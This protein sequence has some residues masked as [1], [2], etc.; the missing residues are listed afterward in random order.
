[1][2]KMK[3]LSALLLCFALFFQL[4]PLKAGA[5]NTQLDLLTELTAAEPEAAFQT[6]KLK[7]TAS[8]DSLTLEFSFALK[9]DYLQDTVQSF[10]DNHSEIDLSDDAAID[11]ACNDATEEELPQIGFSFSCVLDEDTI[12]IPDTLLGTF[13]LWTKGDPAAGEVPEKIGSYT[14]SKGSGANS[15]VLTVDCTLDKKV[16][17]RTDVSAS[18]ALELD[19]ESGGKTDPIPDLEAREGQVFVSVIFSGGGGGTDPDEEIYALTKAQVSRDDSDPNISYTITATTTAAADA[20]VNLNGLTIRD[21]IPAG[22]EVTGVDYNDT[23]LSETDY[24]IADGVLEYTLPEYDGSNELTLAVLTV[25]TRLTAEKYQEYLNSGLGVDWSFKNSASLYGDDPGDPLTVSNEVTSKFKSAFL[26]KDGELVGVNGNR[27]LWTI[28]ADTYFNGNG[29]VYLVDT[30]AGIDTT[31]MYETTTPGDNLSFTVGAEARTATKDTTGFHTPYSDLTTD[32]LNTLTGSDSGDNTN[33]ANAVYYTY[34]SDSNGTDDQAVLVIPLKESD[35]NAPLTVTYYTKLVPLPAGEE[36]YQS[37][38]LK[39]TATMLW[40]WVGYGV[41]PGPGT[42]PVFDFNLTKNVTAANALLQKDDGGYTPEN[43]SM[44]WEFTVNQTGK[45]L[46]DAVVTDVL[47]DRLQAFS[48]LT[49]QIKT[50]TDSAADVTISEG[51]EGDLGQYYSLTKD[52]SANKTTL[53]IHLGTVAA[54]EMYLLTLKTTV[55][56]PDFLSKES[57]ISITNSAQIDAKISGDPVHQE[58]SASKTISNTLLIKDALRLNGTVGTGYNYQTHAVN[59]RI[60][61]NPN[62]VTL[63]TPELKDELPEGATFGELTKVTRTDINGTTSS[64]VTINVTDGNGTVAFSDGLTITLAKTEGTSSGGYSK[65]TETFTFDHKIDDQFVFEFSTVIDEDYRDAKFKTNDS[66]TFT[67]DSTLTGSVPDPTDPTNL[68]KDKQVSVSDDAVQ[69]AAVPPVI[70]SG[71]YYH[72]N[73]TAYPDLGKLDYA[74][75]TIVVNKDAIDM[76]GVRLT[77]SLPD[78][79]ELDPASLSIR[80]ATVAPDGTATPTADPPITEGLTLGY[81]GFTFDIPNANARTPLVITFH[82][83]VVGTADASAMKNTVSLSW[84]GGGSTDSN[85]AGADGAVS[86]NAENFATAT[87]APLLQVLK[88]STNTEYD[89]SGDPLFKLGGAEF[90]LTPMKE[91]GGSW[92]VDA[93]GIPKVRSTS[94]A[95]LANFFF[96]K[97]DVL[98]RLTETG[99]PD[100]YLPDDTPRY[101][102]FPMAG[103]EGNFPTVIG[104]AAVNV[105]TTTSTKQVV[106]NEPKNTAPGGGSYTLSFTKKTDTG[107]PLSGAAFTLRDNSGKLKDKTAVSGADGVVTF[108]HI[109]AGSYTLTET[110]VPAGFQ[111][112]PASVAV[113]VTLSG[114][115]YSVS[116]SGASVSGGAAG[117]YALTN[118]YIRGTVGLIKTDSFSGARVS[119]AEFSVYEAGTDKLTAYL[120]EGGEPGR[121]VL[122]ETNAAGDPVPEYPVR[123]LRGDPLLSSQGGT[124]MLLAGDY[125]ITETTAPNGYLPDND[126]SGTP[127]RHAFSIT[128][129]GQNVVV[130]SQ[131]GAFTNVPCGVISGKKTTTGG[132]PLANAVIGLFPAGTTSFTQEN[133]YNGIKVLSETDGS[134]A[135]TRVPYGTYVIAELSAPSGYTLNRDTSFIV[136]VDQNTAAVTQDDSGNAIVIENKRKPGSSNNNNQGKYGDL[137]IQKTSEDGTLAGFTFVVSGPAGY[138]A[139][140]TTDSEGLIYISGLR[141][142]TYTV[143]EKDTAQTAG[144]YVLPAARTVRLTENGAKLNFYNKLSRSE[145]PAVPSTPPANPNAPDNTGGNGG[146]PGQPGED[147]GGNGIALGN[148]ENEPD[149]SGK[150]AGSGPNTGVPAYYRILPAVSALSLLGFCVCFFWK[151]RGRG[152]SEEK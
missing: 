40:D 35:L 88:T 89:G 61:A 1:M 100:G 131:P 81:S 119:G 108:P 137:S 101:Y 33:S 25:H 106:P 122:S 127:V 114:G 49:A 16:Y 104:S 75:W 2:R 10:L 30:I 18:G 144:R 91:V 117:G 77:D 116:M 99:A 56:D 51:A 68:L 44:T 141:E 86:F 60:T 31:H 105:V 13:E 74:D 73:L 42:S 110:A 102:V 83:L 3:K 12:S 126:A 23:A 6:L 128:S 72:D 82:T 140:F 135:F 69:T 76:T 93:D 55:V 96:L 109:D 80:P 14:V 53:K 27:Y 145:T 121:Y 125:Y 32:D 36:E 149:G 136:T 152:S 123:N 57:S 50:T 95:G 134:F 43:R 87:R 151:K 17:H 147:I 111:P 48:G 70:K 46:T 34:D 142:G 5:E 97:K 20:S 103:H 26:A 38:E 133:L 112:L 85:Q 129:A 24:T 59:W 150:A 113:D 39:N 29:H 22:L 132:S 84:S 139:E 47:D 63:N 41:G 8:E 64:P 45:E 98:Y 120:R 19:L 90:T 67:N 4:L 7:G 143:A 138:Y 66:H 9:D 62:H 146:S 130:E 28:N 79:L 107:T 65:D 92:V 21:P 54:N 148:K 71:R 115:V 52:P 37:R 118:E 58:D 78:F 15:N 124:L 11:A 94:A